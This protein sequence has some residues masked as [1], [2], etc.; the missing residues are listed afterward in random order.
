MISLL[1]RVLCIALLPIASS[2]LSAAAVHYERR[3][4]PTQD[5]LP[6]SAIHSVYRDAEGYLWYGTVNGLCRDDGYRLHVFRPAFLQAQ[7]RVIGCMAE[8]HEGRLWLGSDNGLY[9]LDKADYSIRALAPDRWEGDRINRIQLLPNK[10]QVFIQ[11]RTRLTWTDLEGQPLKESYWL[12]DKALER[13]IAWAIPYGTKTYIAFDDF[14]LCYIDSLHPS[15]QRVTLEP[16]HDKITGMD[17][18]KEHTG[19]W[20]LDKSGQVY[21]LDEAAGRLRIESYACD[22]PAGP[23]SYRIKHSPYDGTLWIMDQTGLTAYKVAEDRRLTRVYSSKDDTPP[24]HM[25]ADVWCDSLFTFV[26]AFDCKNFMLQPKTERFDYIPMQALAERVK[27]NAAVMDMETAGD[28]WWWVFQ[29]RTGLCLVHPD[30]DQAVLSSDCRQAQSYG[31]DRGRVI[32]RSSQGVWVN[33]DMRMHVYRVIRKGASMEVTADLDLSAEAHPEEFVTQ[34]LEDE[35]QRLWVGTNLSLYIYDAVTLKPLATH[36]NLGYVSAIKT[37]DHGHVWATTIEGELCDFGNDIQPTFHP[38][39]QPLSALCI[40]INGDLWVGTQ[41]GNVMRYDHRHEKLDDYSRRIGLNGDRVNQLQND[42]YGHIWIETN[43]RILEYNPLNDA[44][45]IYR[46]NGE[47]IPLTRFLP[48]STMK[49]SAGRICF[50]GIPGVIRFTPSNTLDRKADV[51]TPRVT[52]VTVM[53]HSLRFDTLGH[54]QTSNSIT[55][56]SDD[57]D[58]EI[59]FSSLDHFNVSTIRYAYRLNGVDKGWKYMVAGEN[60]AFYNHLEK[61]NYTFEVKATDSNG[62]WSEPV[63][64]LKIERLPAFYESPLAYCLYCLLAFA[65]LGAIIY[66]VHRRDERKNEQMWSDSQALL[67]MRSYIKDDTPT[68]ERL[69]ESEF[70]AL[71]RTFLNKATQAVTDHLDMADFGVE[72]LAAAVNVSKSTLNRKLKSITGQSPLDYIRAQKMRQAKLWLQ[73]KDRNIT[74]IAISLGYS[75]RK[76]FTACFKKEF[77]VTPTDYRKNLSES[78]DKEEN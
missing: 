39:S 64:I 62:L 28:G 58:L 43:Q 1:I 55:L 65:S 45:R 11:S 36:P 34:L 13:G 29:E 57:R 51:V 23:M 42:I 6:V 46:T 18:D 9:R 53:K 77:G 68:T 37:D 61:G 44:C 31:L 20:L 35:H 21:H 74:E 22:S 78:S 73:D 54:C 17:T 56:R 72:E 24:Y 8:D 60:S 40:M 12:G 67:S 5:Q 47:G 32:A 2:T 26:A 33:H 63:A 50:G 41:L 69:P 52:D 16:G 49:D 15:P 48:T 4:L 19:L 76:Y 66:W 71:D 59:F 30:T 70:L 75:D 3:N 38:T 14:S 27:Y 10:Q 7:D 25:L